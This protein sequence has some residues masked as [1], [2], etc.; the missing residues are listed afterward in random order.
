MAAELLSTLAAIQPSETTLNEAHLPRMFDPGIR[1]SPCRARAWRSPL[2]A[3]ILFMNMGRAP[4][5][6]TCLPY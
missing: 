1:P 3:L 5:G 6:P 2:I 4:K